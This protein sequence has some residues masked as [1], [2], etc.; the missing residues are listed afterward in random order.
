MDSDYYLTKP[1]SETIFFAVLK[2]IQNM[3]EVCSALEQTQ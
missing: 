3:F 2:G 1:L